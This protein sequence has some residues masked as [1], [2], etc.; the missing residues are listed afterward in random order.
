MGSLH[1]M[2]FFRFYIFRS[3]EHHHL[4]GALDFDF[5]PS[6]SDISKIFVPIPNHEK[7]Y[8]TQLMCDVNW[9]KQLIS[10]FCNL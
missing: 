2:I 10:V 1:I 9:I 3:C 5:N 6:S 4:S 8:S 7:F